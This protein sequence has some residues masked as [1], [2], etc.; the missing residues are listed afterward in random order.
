MSN[1]VDEANN[2][3]NVELKNI[4][5]LEKVAIT[6]EVFE[7]TFGEGSENEFTAKVIERDGIYYRVPNTVIGQIKN[8][9]ND[10]SFDYFKVIKSGSGFQTQYTVRPL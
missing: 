6:E 7:R 3:E 1:F 8:L 9:L 5:D 2:Y 10:E 4:A